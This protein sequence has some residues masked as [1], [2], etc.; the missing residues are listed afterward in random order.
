MKGLRLSDKTFLVEFG[1]DYAIFYEVNIGYWYWQ[2]DGIVTPKE[3]TAE[4]WN[5]FVTHNYTN[6]FSCGGFDTLDECKADL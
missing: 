6:G 3:Y 5:E 1:N 4:A 2:L